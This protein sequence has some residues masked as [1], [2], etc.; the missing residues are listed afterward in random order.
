MY[1]ESRTEQPIFIK[2][3]T[4]VSILVFPEIFFIIPLFGFE[5][6]VNIAK[7]KGS[8]L[9]RQSLISSLCNATDQIRFLYCL[10]HPQQISRYCFFVTIFVSNSFHTNLMEL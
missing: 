1:W 6:I 3:I 8:D 10:I 2:T 9:Q 7:E 5:P 4:L